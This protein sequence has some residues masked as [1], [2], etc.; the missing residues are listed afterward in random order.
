[1][2][3]GAAELSP[4]LVIHDRQFEPNAL[5]FPA[6]VRIKLL[7]RNLDSMPAEFESYDMS[8]EVVV[9]GHGEVTIYIGPLEPGSYEFF[10]DFN[11]EMRG[12]V[13]VKPDDAKGK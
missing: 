2:P 6:G 10:N 8:R 9:P 5:A 1:M 4:L 12:S 3:A 11:H 7:V 13:V